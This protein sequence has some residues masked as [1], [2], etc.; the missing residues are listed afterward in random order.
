MGGPVTA[1]DDIALDRE[2]VD[3][4]LEVVPRAPM[5]VLAC[6]HTKHT[7]LGDAA[8]CRACGNRQPILTLERALELA[9]TNE[10]AAALNDDLARR[11][12]ERASAFR[13][14]AEREMKK[15]A[16]HG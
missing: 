12:R 6:G 9:A 14:Y 5:R 15:G 16:G 4:Q 2:T 10:R 13:A 8:H 11:A 3:A 1:R 7:F